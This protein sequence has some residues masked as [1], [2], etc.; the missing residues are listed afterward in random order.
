MSQENPIFARPEVEVSTRQ[1]LLACKCQEMAR[2][3]TFSQPDA[4]DHHTDT[5]AAFGALRSTLLTSLK[6]LK[7]TDVELARAVE[8][9]AKGASFTS[10]D[11][12]SYIDQMVTM[13]RETIYGGA[14]VRPDLF[15]VE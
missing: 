10:Y 13:L 7:P 14:T 12:D 11:N 4:P 9:V 8:D 15:T 1:F 5:L 6:L 2:G 3:G